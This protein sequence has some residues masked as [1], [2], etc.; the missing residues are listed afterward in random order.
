[1]HMICYISKYTG[2]DNITEVLADIRKTAK[3]HNQAA[4]ITGVLFFHE[5]QFLQVIEGEEGRLRKLMANIEKDPRHTDV[6]VLIDTEVKKRGFN[7]W[8]M[9]T[10]ILGEGHKFE[11]TMMKDLTESFKRNLMPQSDTLIYFYKTLLSQPTYKTKSL[12]SMLL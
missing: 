10:L 8:N 7:N 11:A 2:L 5:G 4:M 12:L 9:D 6:D 1:M 3:E